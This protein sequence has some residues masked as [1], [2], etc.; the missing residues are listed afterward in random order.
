MRK[1]NIV[2]IF[3]DDQRFDT[4]HAWGNEDII[5]PNLDALAKRG[6]SFVNAHIPSGTSGAVCMPSRA[7][8]NTGRT[9]FHI[10]DE[11]QRISDEYALLGETLMEAGYNTFGTGKWHNGTRAYARSFNHGA[12]IYFGGMQDHWN[13]PA[14]DFD[15][16]GEYNNRL[17]K[18]NDPMHTKNRQEFIA[19][20]I[21]AGKHS[22]ELFADVTIDFIN[23][24]T[25]DQP[26]YAYMSL[27]APHDPRSMPDR[28]M[29]MYADVDISL[30]ENFSGYHS[31][32][33]GNTQCRDELLAP[34]P[35][36][37]EDT[38]HQI[39]EYYAM[40]T[41]I[42]H[43]VGRVM[44]AL[45]AQGMM[46]NTLVIFAADNGLSVG[47]H[48]LFGK[49]NH[50]EHSI[51]VP[52]IIAGPN[53]PQDAVRDAY[54]YLLDIFPTLCDLTATAIPD[55]VEGISF[56]PCIGNPEFKT[57]E[58]LYFAYTDK[59]RS[60]KDDQYKLMEFVHDGVLTTK[61]F[62]FIHDP[63]EMADLS[64][65]V[66]HQERIQSLRQVMYR[67]RDE[68]DD[69]QHPLGES[70]WTQYREIMYQ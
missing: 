57:R 53:L 34:Y 4:I 48:G 38:I 36:T 6:V 29:D 41:H 62:D 16:T 44:K 15:P 47:Q 58:Q 10:T 32:E 28:Y 21:A 59:I 33:Y 46:D 35:R 65:M 17:Y 14:H 20:H 2:F 67:M 63:L 1:P 39:K 3:A 56:A 27:M 7:M 9:L 26:F 22:T 70:Y 5:T 60:V 11:G 23:Q 18:I 19:D 61:L 43:E 52:L 40:I 31:V 64:A 42:D 49:Q 24:Q 8:L 69:E 25:D 66:E 51:R 54:V 37:K 13:V 50:F 45:E 12:E 30:P 68:W 55:T